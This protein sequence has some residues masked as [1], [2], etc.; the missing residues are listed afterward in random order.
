MRILIVIGFLFYNLGLFAQQSTLKGVVKHKNSS[1]PFVNVHLD[2]LHL[3]TT[4][5]KN[6]FF[7]FK[8]L[9]KGM[10]RL[11]VTALGFQPFFK[12]IQIEK[13]SVVEY[14]V[15]LEELSQNLSE[16]VVT[17]SNQRV[18]IGDSPV[19]VNTIGTQTLQSVNAISLA[20]GLNYSPG[21]RLE[22]NCQNCGFTQVRMNGLDGSYSQILVN[23]RPSF[24]ALMGVYGLEML[25]VNMIEKIE[26]VRGGGS[27]LYGG[28]AIAGTINIITKDPILNSFEVGLNY[29]FL[30]FQ[31]PDRVIHFNGTL[32]SNDLKKGISIYGMNRDRDFWDANG[33]GF[34]EITKLKN[35]TVGADAFWRINDRNRLRLGISFTNEFRRGGNRFHLQPHEAD[36]TE[37]LK[38]DILG[39]Q[40]SY[41]WMSKNFKHEIGVFAA[42]NYVQ[43][44]SY[45]GA[46]G[47]QLQIGDSLTESVILA[48]NAYGKSDDLTIIGGIQY[49]GNWHKKL[50]FLA[51]LDLRFNRVNDQMLGYK[52]T[53]QQDVYTNGIFA[54]LNYRVHPRVQIVAG[55]RLDLL[56]IA[57][58]YAFVQNVYQD[59][60]LLPVFVPRVVVMYEIVKDLKWRTSFAQGYKGPQAFDEDLHIE[61]VGGAAMFTKL[62]SNLVAEKS[63]SINTSFQYSLTKNKFQMNAMIEGFFTHIQNPFIT[64]NPE[65]L[66][67]GVAVKTKRNGDGAYVAGVNLE[68]NMWYSS[69]FNLQL[70]ATVQA[71]KYMTNEIIWSP[72]SITDLNK[73][74][75]ITTKEMLRTPTW[76]GYFT[77]TFTLVKNLSI[78]YSGTLTGSM[79]VPHVINSDNEYTVIKKTPLFFDNSI[80]V[81]YRFVLK[82]QMHLDLFVGVNNLWNSYQRDFDTGM[83]RDAGYIYGPNR[84]R[85]IFT[86]FKLGWNN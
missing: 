49:R 39:T 68:Y 15:E 82:K 50:N 13:D 1:I 60:K 85:T 44:D 12:D 28:N 19:M 3:N 32:V 58:N 72:D 67:N 4:S 70:G 24:S 22:T 74:S 56:S 64:A 27:V 69:W 75:L 73:D 33:D 42:L 35:T 84:P 48:L 61:T 66:D 80:K 62:D 18:K 11:E 57:G 20:D 54:E 21:L 26:I 37:Q 40:L 14:V 25:P 34:S 71:A 53:I 36:L 16:V 86:G 83:Y 31:R 30:N 29:G 46:G 23:S 81:N 41:D 5:D 45:Y 77:F 6:G 10:Y 76:Y 9:Q 59:R 7:E 52:R 79:L 55:A 8:N 38:H 43:R 51:G 17:G 47:K 63:N 65:E 78:S 2:P